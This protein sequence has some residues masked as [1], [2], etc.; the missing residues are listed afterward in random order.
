[1]NSQ[2]I[3]PTSA[4]EIKREWFLFDVKDKVLGRI[5]SDIAEKLMGKNKPYYVRNLDCGN[6]VVVINCKS[7]AVTGKKEKE[8][9]Y[10]RYSGYPGGITTKPLWKLREE[11]PTE[12]L[13]RAVK[14]MLPKNKL[15]D[16]LMTRLYVFEGE[17]HPY[18]AKL[19]K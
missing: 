1:M 11:H 2:H 16:Q 7:V 6:Y 10:T 12:L 5:A 18:G 19:K 4:N 13:T 14:G 8:K 3:Q 15:R 17:D 9:L